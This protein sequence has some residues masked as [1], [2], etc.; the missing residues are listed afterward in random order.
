[1]ET[2][3]KIDSI[4]KILVDSWAFYKENL[5]KI[6]SMVIKLM[7]PLLVASF[8]VMAFFTT[9]DPSDLMSAIINVIISILIIVLAYGPMIYIAFLFKAKYENKEKSEYSLKNNYRNTVNFLNKVFTTAFLQTIFIFILGF[10]TGIVLAGAKNSG[11]DL[12]S[13]KSTLMLFIVLY[14]IPATIYSVYWKFAASAVFLNKTER[15]KKALAYSKSIVKGRWWKTVWY[16]LALGFIIFVAIF[17]GQLII[18]VLLKGTFIGITVTGIFAALCY[19]FAMIVNLKTFLTFD[20]TKAQD[21]NLAS[22]V[23]IIEVVEVVN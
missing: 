6:S 8:I 13:L 23:E 19:S 17:V 20:A 7:L 15:N 21:E 5:N 14:L 12:R 9:Q 4:K 16:Q 1:M 3:I 11:S 2:N 22:V 18:S 10:V